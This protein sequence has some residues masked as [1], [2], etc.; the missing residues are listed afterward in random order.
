MQK[1]Q[2]K[3]GGCNPNLVFRQKTNKPK[4]HVLQ[5]M[6]FLTANFETLTMYMSAQVREKAAGLPLIASL[7]HAQECSSN[8]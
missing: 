7:S 5:E 6:T 8:I 2:K 1:Y 4:R 3:K